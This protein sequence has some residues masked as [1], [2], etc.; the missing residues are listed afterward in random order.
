MFMACSFGFLDVCQWLFKHGSK[1]DIKK[2]TYDNVTPFEISLNNNHLKVCQ[3]LIRKGALNSS[4]KKNNNT[5]VKNIFLNI[6]REGLIFYPHCLNRHNNFMKLH[7]W[8]QH[9][10]NEYYSFK[11]YLL[12]NSWYSQRGTNNKCLLWMLGRHGDCFRI[13]FISLISEFLGV[14][15]EESFKNVK[16]FLKDSRTIQNMSHRVA[17]KSHCLYNKK[18]RKR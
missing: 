13:I 4:E 9:I 1:K 15:N 14:E 8:S 18:K 2:T 10:I 5:L 7:K 11:F 17:D 12:P 3:W 6:R 16:Q